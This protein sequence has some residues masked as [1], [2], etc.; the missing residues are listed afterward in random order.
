MFPVEIDGCTLV[1]LRRNPS[2]WGRPF[3]VVAGGLLSYDGDTLT[4]ENDGV[5][6]PI[7][8]DEL[9]DIM[10]VHADTMIPECRGFD[11]FLIRD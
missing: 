8:D 5:R 3:S 11:R 10:D 6:Q 2:R 7:S 1:I 9:A 4:M